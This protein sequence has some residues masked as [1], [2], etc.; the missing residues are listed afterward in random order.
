MPHC[1]VRGGPVPTG[2]HIYKQHIE[3]A[4]KEAILGYKS[5][6]VAHIRMLVDQYKCTDMCAI[7]GPNAVQKVPKMGIIGDLG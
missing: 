3:I 4:C 5:L 7:Y 1:C 2:Q 6:V